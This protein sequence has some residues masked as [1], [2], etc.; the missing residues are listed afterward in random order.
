MERHPAPG[1]LWALTHAAVL[2]HGPR[3]PSCTGGG[4]RAHGGRGLPAK[5]QLKAGGLIGRP[6]LLHD[7]PKTAQLGRV[8][9]VH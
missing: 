7:T 3:G 6:A 5:G 4:A 9:K 8:P 1:Y 2:G